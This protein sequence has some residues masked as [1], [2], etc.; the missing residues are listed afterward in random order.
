MTG[1]KGAHGGGKGAHGSSRFIRHL[2]MKR[3]LGIKSSGSVWPA[4]KM[5]GRDRRR[6]T[7]WDLKLNCIA[8]EGK[9]FAQDTQEGGA[10]EFVLIP[11]S[12]EERGAKGSSLVGDDDEYVPETEPQDDMVNG[13]IGPCANQGRKRLGTM[14]HEWLRLISDVENESGKT[15]MGSSKVQVDNVKLEEESDKLN[16]VK[17]EKEKPCKIKL[18]EK[19]DIIKLK[20]EE[21]DSIK[22]KNEEPNNVK[23]EKEESDSLSRP[24]LATAAANSGSSAGR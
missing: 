19:P 16:N 17:L 5:P 18:K 7:W 20:E 21:L 1:G 12:D 4:K 15:D 11:D 10:D 14:L 23:L 22:L 13:H 24:V 9:D 2:R 6:G 8:I 3:A